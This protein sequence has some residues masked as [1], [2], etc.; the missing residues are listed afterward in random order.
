MKIVICIFLFCLAPGICLAQSKK[1]PV[2][3]S[4]S[5]IDTV[6]QGV[7]FALKEAIRV[8][9]SFRFVDHEEALTTPRIVV[10]ITS[11]DTTI[12]SA[13]GSASAIAIIFLYDSLAMP[14]RGP[15]SRVS[16]CP[17][18]EI[19]LKS[20]ARTPCL[21]LIRRLNHFGGTG[22]ISGKISDFIIRARRT[23]DGERRGT[24]SPNVIKVRSGAP[25]LLNEC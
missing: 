14:A 4:H 13:K 19:G 6:G 15:L 17:A 8:S 10:Q 5:G 12:G 2:A 9:H 3:L 18:A 1:I 24:A 23:L 20:A 21:R 11:L 16:F 7:A 25:L 22:R